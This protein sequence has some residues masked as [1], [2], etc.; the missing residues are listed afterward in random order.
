V[1]DQLYVRIRGRVQ[2]PFDKEKLRALVKRGQLS[3]MHEVSPDGNDW[4][5]ASEYQEL[6]ATEAKQGIQESELT[7]E[8]GQP[9]G[10]E[11]VWYYSVNGV[12]AGP[13]TFEQLQ[14]Q[15]SP[16]HLSSDDLV[17]KEG[18]KEWV[19]GATVP[20]LLF[21]TAPRVEE[22]PFEPTTGASKLSAGVLRT[23]KDSQAWIR[24]IAFYFFITFFCALLAGLYFIGRGIHAHFGM[25]VAIGIYWLF[26][27]AIFFYAGWL[28]HSYRK[29]VI[30]VLKDK[31]PAKL[32]NALQSLRTLW[33]FV[34]ILLIVLLV[35]GIA[36][37]VLVFSD[38]AFNGPA[39]G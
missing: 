37:A 7:A 39:F 25:P 24:F 3:R 38:I 30:T 14:A 15:A 26:Y 32:D 31:S 28:L 19:S 17:W 10:Q 18:M 8:D 21:G 33:I 12:Q 35:N 4:K 16:G 9:I 20:G 1:E 36:A 11:A 6:F 13:V 22:S 5:Q 29:N 2:G 23:L 27:A 34:S